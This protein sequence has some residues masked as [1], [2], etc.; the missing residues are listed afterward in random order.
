MLEDEKQ[1]VKKRA[2]FGVE[3]EGRRETRK[4]RKGNREAT[5]RRMRSVGPPANWMTYV[6]MY[7]LSHQQTVILSF[8]LACLFAWCYRVLA[9]RDPFFLH[10]IT[11][12]VKP[13][14]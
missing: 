7:A 2:A 8:F 11:G 14:Y 5:L 9:A 10:I 13:N 12:E 4:G 1:T 3:G 6:V